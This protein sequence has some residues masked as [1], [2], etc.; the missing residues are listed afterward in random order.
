MSQIIRIKRKGRY[1]RDEQYFLGPYDPQG[2]AP[3]YKTGH[4]MIAGL[5]AGTF[6]SAGRHGFQLTD[7]AWLPQDSLG[8]I[9][10]ILR[11]LDDFSLE[12]DT[13]LSLNRRGFSLAWIT[14][15][16]KG[17]AG[18]RSDESGPLIE[19]MAGSAMCL[20]LSRGFVIPDNPELLRSLLVHL[21]LCSCFDLII[22]TGGT[23][24]APR[25]IT[26]ETT[27]KVMDRR[28]PGFEL[29]M[30]SHSLTRTPHAGISRAAAGTLGQSMIINLPGSPKGV[31]ENLEAVLPAIEHGLKKLQGDQSDCGAKV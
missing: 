23:G 24:L 13:Q 31:R 19:E 1:S 5:R 4:E 18:Q 22:T 7:K 15:S 8:S 2:T 27:L 3:G 28:L 20:S 12:E 29:A 10:L 14:L 30:L 16:D 21:C 11:S 25:D 9:F 6:L 17:A 26:P